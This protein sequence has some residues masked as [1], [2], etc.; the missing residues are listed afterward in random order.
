MS[1]TPFNVSIGSNVIERTECTKF[2]GIYIDHRLNYN[3]H[4]MT[5]S[6]K[7]SQISG[8]MRRI[9]NF[10]PPSVLRQVYFSLFQSVMDY[11]IV[12]WGGC[13]VTNRNRLIQVQK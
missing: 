3:V 9:A 2:L 4:V 5:L 11:G 7:L 8:I 13:G 6:K 12:V 10:M 1:T